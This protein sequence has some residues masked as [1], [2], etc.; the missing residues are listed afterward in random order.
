MTTLDVEKLQLEL[1]RIELRATL[2]A[3]EDDM[4][5]TVLSCPCG[6]RRYLPPLA[7][8]GSMMPPAAEFG[9]LHGGHSQ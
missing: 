9:I 1:A 5:G 6:A 3:M 4:L 2:R 7:D 8:T